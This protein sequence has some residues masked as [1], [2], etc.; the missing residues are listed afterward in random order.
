MI[1]TSAAH[2]TA[3]GA[4]RESPLIIRRRSCVGFKRENRRFRRFARRNLG[5]IVHTNFEY[6]SHNPD[7]YRRAYDQLRV[8]LSCLALDLIAI[9]RQVR[10]KT[11]GLN[12]TRIQYLARV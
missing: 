4:F 2:T 11:P 8:G 6:K 7:P 5:P 9:H 3:I 12:C 10:R 1:L